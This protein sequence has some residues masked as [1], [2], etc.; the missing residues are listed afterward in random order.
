MITDKV[1]EYKKTK[2]AVTLLRRL[3]AWSDIEKVCK[4]ISCKEV[5]LYSVCLDGNVTI[6]IS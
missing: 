1:Q 3:K 6:I 4:Y 5:I 2:D